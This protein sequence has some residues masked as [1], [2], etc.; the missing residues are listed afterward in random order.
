[1]AGK[2]ENGSGIEAIGR[3]TR[4]STAKTNW[5]TLYAANPDLFCNGLKE[6]TFVL[7]IGT[8][9][10]CGSVGQPDVKPLVS[11]GGQ[12]QSLDSCRTCFV[13]QTGIDEPIGFA[14]KGVD[15]PHDAAWRAER[16]RP[17][18]PIP[19]PNRNSRF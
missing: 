16:R 1:M 10:S 2:A 11:E 17:R 6:R 4:P 14:P 18:F 5:G 3:E 9:P 8:A 19:L 15:H 12:G 13:D 7:W